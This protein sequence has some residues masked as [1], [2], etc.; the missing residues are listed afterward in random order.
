M[1]IATHASVKKVV[2][3]SRYMAILSHKEK[4]NNNKKLKNNINEKNQT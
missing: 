4:N 3:C 1:P 2:T